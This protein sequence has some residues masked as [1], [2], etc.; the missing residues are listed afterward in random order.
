MRSWR[1]VVA[2]L[3]I[4]AVASTALSGCRSGAT[5]EMVLSAHGQSYGKLSFEL[6]G[7]S[8][9]GLFPGARRRISVTVVNKLEH[10]IRLRSLDG[11]LK[12][13]S[14]RECPATSANL[15]I[16][17]YDGVLPVTVKAHARAK[18]DGAVPVTM[19]KNVSPKCSSTRF[20]I[21]LSATGSQAAR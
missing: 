13:S 5:E 6:E 14:R 21:V 16:G 1:D 8:L 11:R 20:S 12:S 9:T 2:T 4:G 3:V 7:G 15:N 10:P 18:L 19:P 17:G